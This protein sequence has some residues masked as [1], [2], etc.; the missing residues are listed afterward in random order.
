MYR[1]SYR[2]LVPGWSAKPLWV[3]VGAGNSVVVVDVPRWGPMLQGRGRSHG[4]NGAVTP[5]DFFVDREPLGQRVLSSGLLA[6]I[7]SGEHIG[8]SDVEV[9]VALLR[10]AHSEL[11]AYGTDGA[12]R[13]NEDEM[14]LILGACRLLLKRI[15]VDLDLPFSDFRTFRSHWL[16]NEGYGS[17][18][19]R[20]DILNGLF[21]PV[22]LK[23]ARLED[24]EIVSTL[25]RPVT[26]HPGTGWSRVD[27]EINELRRHFAGARSEQDYRNVGNDCVAVLERLSEAVFDP[28]RHHQEGETIPPVP[29]T[30]LRIGRFVEDAAAGPANQEVR[31]VARAVIELAQAVKHRS[32]PSRRDAGIAA[33]SVIQLANILRRLAEE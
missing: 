12:Q 33:D 2:F 15:G 32:A 10:L 25:A 21:E 18:Q 11:E 8:R 17:W 30:K 26:S 1:I 29:N 13:T 7:R 27:A 3:P 9:G 24:S 14:R 20:R 28:D 16:A 6:R 5:E 4:H 23:L 22:H 19:A 31:K